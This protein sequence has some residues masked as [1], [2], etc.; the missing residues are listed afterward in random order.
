MGLEFGLFD[1]ATVCVPWLYVNG[2]VSP[3][4][5][6]YAWNVTDT[7]ATRIPFQIPPGRYIH[8]YLHTY[9]RLLSILGLTVATC[10]RRG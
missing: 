10:M 1:F 3:A 6:V 5:C 4:P 8:T 7:A 9:G 2:S